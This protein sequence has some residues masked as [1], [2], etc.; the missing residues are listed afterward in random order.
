MSLHVH[1]KPSQSE[2]LPRNIVNKE[3]RARRRGDRADRIQERAVDNRYY[4]CCKRPLTWRLCKILDLFN[5][6][7]KR[8]I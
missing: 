6:I 1:I 5:I 3:V 2:K 8:I 4:C 7:K